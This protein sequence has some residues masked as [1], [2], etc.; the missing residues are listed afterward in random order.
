MAVPP[1]PLKVCGSRQAELSLHRSL[2]FPSV[3]ER[4]ETCNRGELALPVGLLGV[5]VHSNR[6]AMAALGAAA[7]DHISATPSGHS[8]SKPVDA[9][10]AANLGLV[11]SL[12]HLLSFK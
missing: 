5:A 10:P 9:H 11:G 3:G 6:D 7:L 1:H 8:F 12:W 2:S 4:E